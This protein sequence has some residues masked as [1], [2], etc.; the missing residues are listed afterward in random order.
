MFNCF[1]HFI[2]LPLSFTKQ[3]AWEFICL[4]VE[5][6][7][8]KKIVQF[9]TSFNT[10]KHWIRYEFNTSLLHHEAS[11]LYKAEFNF[12]WI[13]IITKLLYQVVIVVFMWVESLLNITTTI[14]MTFWV[15]ETK[16]LHIRNFLGQYSIYIN[17]YLLTKINY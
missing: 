13:L 17:F 1:C 2:V 11:L 6:Y 4:S 9:L 10:I 8:K 16:H 12:H 15:Y 14:T 5:L 7:K 3:N